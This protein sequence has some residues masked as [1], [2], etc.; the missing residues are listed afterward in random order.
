MVLA[1]L[2]RLSDRPTLDELMERPSW[3]RYALCRGTGPDLFFPAHGGSTAAVQALCAV[4]RVREE[5]ASYAAETGSSGIWAGQSQ[6]PHAGL[7]LSSG[8]T[9]SARVAAMP[10]R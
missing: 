4:C 5:C 3:Q 7:I 9:N 1:S 10:Q 6:K 8:V 2:A